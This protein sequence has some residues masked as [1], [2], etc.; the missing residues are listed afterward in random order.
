MTT[1]VANGNNNARSLVF[2]RYE[3]GLKKCPIL[4][5]WDGIASFGDSGPNCTI[6]R[7][8]SGKTI[9]VI[10]RSLCY[11][12]SLRRSVKQSGECALH[13]VCTAHVVH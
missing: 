7:D 3:E 2:E 4:G 13:I 5:S 1:L 12:Y 10:S 9:T 6:K 11:R 8:Y